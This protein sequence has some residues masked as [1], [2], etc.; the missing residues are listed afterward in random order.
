M[1]VA[2]RKGLISFARKNGGWSLA[3]TDFAGVAGDRGAL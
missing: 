1:L 3:R 2:T